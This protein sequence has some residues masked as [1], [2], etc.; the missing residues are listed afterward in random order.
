MVTHVGRA[1][2]VANTAQP[3]VCDTTLLLLL[4]LLLLPPRALLR[5]DHAQIK[6]LHGR[7]RGCQYKIRLYL[8][9]TLSG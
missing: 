6:W 7:I 9:N 3:R 1:R 4:L 2:A 8:C 5:P